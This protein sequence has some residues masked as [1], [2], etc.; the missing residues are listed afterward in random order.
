MRC[1]ENAGSPWLSR[2]H[3][4]VGPAHSQ[5]VARTATA[6]EQ[7]RWPLTQPEHHGLQLAKYAFADEA[8][9]AALA[10]GVATVLLKAITAK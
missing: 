4:A 5:F 6:N 2:T 3:A 9:K 1:P 7:W 10:G 8:R